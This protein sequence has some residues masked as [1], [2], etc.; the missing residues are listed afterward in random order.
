LSLEL[1][2]CWGGGR[3]PFYRMGRGW[4]RGKF[5]PDVDQQAQRGSKR[6]GGDTD[7]HGTIP[8]CFDL[9]ASVP[10]RVKTGKRPSQAPDV[11][12]KS[13]GSFTLSRLEL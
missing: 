7:P 1:L 5:P 11:R 13:P 9:R 3:V 6:G 12:G 2:F 10:A 8:D 4:E